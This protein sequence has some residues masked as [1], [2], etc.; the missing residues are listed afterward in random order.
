MTDAISNYGRRAQSDVSLRSSLEKT[1]RKAATSTAS[2]AA[3]IGT[4]V[5]KPVSGPGP[6]QLH[7]T[8][9]ADKAMAEPDFDKVKVD[10]IKKALQDGQYPLNPRRIAES[11][12]AIEQMIRE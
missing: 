3:P 2:L 11:F 10:S 12:Y 6:D 1:D 4:G 5:A 9:V 7:M 8:N